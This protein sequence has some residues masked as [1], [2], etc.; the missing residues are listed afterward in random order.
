MTKLDE[1]ALNYPKTPVRPVVETLHGQ[2]IVDEY[3]W[4]ED[5]TNPEV[6]GWIKD[7]TSHFRNIT[8]RILGR[9]TIRRRV[10]ELSRIEETLLPRETATGWFYRRKLPTKQQ[11]V[12]LFR[13]KVGTQT[14][15]VLLDIN[16]LDPSGVTAIEDWYVSPDGRY[17]VY[18][19]SQKGAE[20]ATLHVMDLTDKSVLPDRIERTRHS[21]IMWNKDNTGFFYMRFP[22]QGEVPTGEE[23]F[24]SHVRYHEIGAEARGDPIIY[25]N[26]AKPHEY[27]IF[28]LSPDNTY[29]II[30]SFRF[31]EVDLYF[32]DLTTQ[33]PEVHPIVTESKW[34]FNT[35]IGEQNIYFRSNHEIPHFALY[36]TTR[37]Q[38]AI[39]KWERIVSPEEGTLE[40]AWLI[41]DKLVL[42]WLHNVT[43][44]LTLHHSDGTIIHKIATPTNGTLTSWLSAPRFVFDNFPIHYQSWVNPPQI[45][46]YNITTNQVT[47]FATLQVPLDSDQFV[48]KRLWYSSKDQTKVHMFVLHR[49]D[50]E[51]DGR[52][53]TILYGYGGFGISMNPSFNR[54]FLTWIE[55]GGVVAIANIRGGME[56]GDEWHQAGRLEKKQNVFD[57]FIAAAEYLIAQ[58]YCS[59]DTLGIYGAS[60]GGLLVGAVTVQRPELL[61]AVY[62][63]V[64]LLDMVRYHH[65]SLGKTWIPEY[66]D[67]EDSEHFRWLYAYSPY[68][69]VEKNT[70]YPA[71][72]LH[73]AEA[74]TR[75]EPIHAMKMAA[76]LQ[77]QT[78]SQNPVLFWLEP[79]TGH[80]VGTPLDKAI[81]QTTDILAFFAWQLGLFSHND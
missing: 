41:Q 32:V 9:E 25:Q 22:F 18:G 39:S 21:P 6:K 58:K 17:L 30:T 69:H 10:E 53:A 5:L 76:L 79:A 1:G 15:D 37:D 78:S 71:V 19:V 24:H 46:S 57:D 61:R 20:W 67:P 51:L 28:S 80:G 56:F 29:M 70:A 75:V 62:C 60:N 55:Q 43:H 64:P 42:L 63:S 12:L 47:K 23:Q 38:L 65:F 44:S 4:L 48:V 26:P 2:K 36:R 68:H 54:T 27:P 13:S 50:L 77:A 7:Q 31:T 73:T 52:N 72:L 74:D 3:R 34:L 40:Y 11:P 33:P 66:G 14:E 8:K 49:P 81:T 45:L 35:L 59:P 16:Q